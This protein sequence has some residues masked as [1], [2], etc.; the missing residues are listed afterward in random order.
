MLREVQSQFI[1]HVAEA[2]QGFQKQ[3]DGRQEQNKFQAL[4]KGVK[5]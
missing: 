2:H 5:S 4:A 3:G 1:H